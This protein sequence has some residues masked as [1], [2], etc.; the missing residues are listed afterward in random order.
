MK[1]ALDYDGTYTADPEMWNEVIEVFKN[2]GHEVT[3]V[4]SRFATNPPTLVPLDI[5]CCSFRAKC[6]SFA[7]DIWIDDNPWS[8]HI[9]YPRDSSGNVGS[10]GRVG[11]L[12][13][14]K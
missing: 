11:V 3:C 7:A 8:I 13:P 14:E 9:D 2:H 10:P 5:V 12:S 6:R 4:S 1:I